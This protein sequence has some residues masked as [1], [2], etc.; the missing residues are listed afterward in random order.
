MSQAMYASSLN[1]VALMNKCLGN[2]ETSIDLYTKALHI[3]EESLGRNHS[4]YAVTLANLGAGYNAFAEKTSGEE[5]TQLLERYSM[6]V[7]LLCR[8]VI[9][10]QGEGGARGCTLSA[11]QK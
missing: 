2:V 3:Y 10:P 11:A 4:S 1:N 9:A 7:S 6:L 8:C 5:R